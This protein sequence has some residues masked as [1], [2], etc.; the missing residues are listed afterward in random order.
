[1]TTV[2]RAVCSS[3]RALA[4]RAGGTMRELVLVSTRD[5]LVC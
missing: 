1:M 4:D 3:T 5:Q 2:Q